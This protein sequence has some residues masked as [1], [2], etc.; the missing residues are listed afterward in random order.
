[1]PKEFD[2]WVKSDMTVKLTITDTGVLEKAL[3]L[4]EAGAAVTDTVR[5]TG[6]RE[7]CDYSLLTSVTIPDSVTSIGDGAFSS[8]DWLSD[9]VI[10]ETVTEIGDRAF[11]D[12]YS[13]E[14]VIVPATVTSVGDDAFAECNNLE[15]ATILGKA[16]SIGSRA[17]AWCDSLVITAPAGSPAEH[18]AQSNGIVF[19]SKG[20]QAGGRKQSAVPLLV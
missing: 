20:T 8:C 16:T 2:E 9:V 5:G 7:F 3:L 12:C 15:S 18:Y 13:L 10:P 19:E 6:E 17:F 4:D 11:F 1:L 14:T